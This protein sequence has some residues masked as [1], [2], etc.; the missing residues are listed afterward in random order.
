MFRPAEPT[1]LGRMYVVWHDA[2]KATH[3][4]LSDAAFDEIAEMVKNQYLPNAAFVVEENDEGTVTAFMG[5]TDNSIDALFVHPE[6][7]GAGIGS[8][9][10]QRMQKAHT[11][12]ILEV[13][14][15]NPSALA[16]YE[17]HGF[18]V[19]KREPTDDQGRPFPILHMRWPA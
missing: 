12:V 14:E 16:F 17:K 10:V 6:C 19:V 3:H 8:K 1:D 9:F 15:Q 7:H 18:K 2:V 13:N 4:F 11:S 5:T